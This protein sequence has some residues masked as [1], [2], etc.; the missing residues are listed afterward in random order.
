M[1]E[2]NFTVEEANAI[3]QAR[4]LARYRKMRDV[5]LATFGPPGKRTP[6]GALILEEL[7]KFTNWKTTIR[8]QDTT[9]QTD[10]YRTGIKEGR[11]EVM[12]AIHNL[13]EWKES[14]HVN[15]GNGST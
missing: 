15:T 7:E 5:F 14:E 9:G 6:H 8:E 1:P 3:E 2:T 12:Q 4:R 11:R 10:I 13:I